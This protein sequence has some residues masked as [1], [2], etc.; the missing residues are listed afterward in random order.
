MSVS[1]DGV[2]AVYDEQHRK[3]RKEHRCDACKET[4]RVGDRYTSLHLVYDGTAQTIKRY[5][6]CQALHEHLR[7]KCSY[8][9]DMW[10]MERLD[11]GE[12]Y[13]TEWGECPP[14]IQRLA[15]LT[16]DEAQKELCDV[17]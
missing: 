17:E 7:E 4:I 6:R 16:P 13:E 12:S 10:P 11:C 3:A 15:F 1:C 5:A 14:E 8:Y 2:N 9:G